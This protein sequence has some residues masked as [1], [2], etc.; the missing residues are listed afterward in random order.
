[1][2]INSPVYG[3]HAGDVVLRADA[4]REQSIPDLPR[5]HCWVLSL[6][7]G[8]GVNYKRSCYFG[9]ASADNARLEAPRLV[10][11]T[12]S[13]EDNERSEDLPP[14]RQ[15][16]IFS[17]LHQHK[18]SNMTMSFIYGVR[19]NAGDSRS[20]LKTGRSRVRFPMG[21]LAFFIDIIL[22]AALWSWD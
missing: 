12:R 19:G 13:K 18:S 5:E 16:N 22:P 20:V 15:I 1:L 10:V 7:V 9:F 2:F 21:S 8:N 14:P 11:S 17:P 4:F 3:G 6:I